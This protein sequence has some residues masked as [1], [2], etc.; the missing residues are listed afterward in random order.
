MKNFSDLLATDRSIDVILQL[1]A[2]TQNGVPICC[3]EINHDVLW[4]TLLSD[5]ITLQKQVNLH[6]Q[7]DIEISMWGKTYCS[8][9]ET[10][11]V[12]QS[13]QVDG[14][15]IVPGWTHLASYHNDHDW[16]GATSYLGFNGT[17][18]LHI[19]APFYRWRHEITGQG[20]LLVPDH[21]SSS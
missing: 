20:W 9:R 3:V 21:S 12:L 15:E 5:P 14:F 8:D 11:V 2:I 16:C 19:P 7:I 6:Q 1:S 17:W 18:S 10:A 4:H 13:L